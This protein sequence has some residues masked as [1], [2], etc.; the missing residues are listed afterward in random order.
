[1]FFGHGNQAINEFV[2]RLAVFKKEKYKNIK[3]YK[4]NSIKKQIFCKCNTPR[5]GETSAFLSKIEKE[6][7]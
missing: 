2:N 1:M 5:R 7:V 3:K 4:M 6:T